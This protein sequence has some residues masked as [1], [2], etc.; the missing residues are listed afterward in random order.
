MRKM[1][2]L[3]DHAKL[4]FCLWD[5]IPIV[6]IAAV[7]IV[8]FIKRHKMKK[9]ERKLLEDLEVFESEKVEENG[10]DD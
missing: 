7:V 9:E 1:N 10:K 6:L 8:F 5:I 2:D 4:G 3:L